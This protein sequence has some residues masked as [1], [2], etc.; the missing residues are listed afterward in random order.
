MKLTF[1]FWRRFGTGLLAFLPVLMVPGGIAAEVPALEVGL[2]V[3]DISP[4]LPI[5]LA[6]YAGRKR[7]A[8]RA[9]HPLLAQALAFKNPSGE[10]F[11]FLALDNCEVSHAF[12]QPILARLAEEFQLKP[13]EVALVCSHTHS[14]PVLADTLEGMGPR[15]PEERERINNYSRLL[16]AK[17][18]ETVGAALTNFQPAWLE[19]GTGRATFAMN[20]RVYADDKVVFGD[21]P[22]GPADWD[23]PVLRIKTTDGTLRAIVF[24]YSCHGTSVRTGDDWYV[25]SGEYMAYARQHLETLHPG[26]TAMFLTGMGADSDPAP[27]GRLLDAKRHGLELAGAVVGV[28]DHP[29][30]PVRGAFKL[31]YEEVDLP[32]ADPPTREQIEKDA[33]GKDIYVQHRAAAYLQRMKENQPLPQ[34]VKLPVAALRVGEDLTFLIVGGEVVVDYSHRLKRALS[35]DHPWTV[36][37]AYEV[38]C[39]IPSARLIKE[40]G[41]ETESSLIYY[42]LYG[43]FRGRVEDLLVNRLSAMVATLRAR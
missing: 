13:G 5:W 17:L 35:Q 9:E 19:Q 32:L 6:G 14:G 37:Y 22:D 36:G 26:A 41:Y 18:V 23:V 12:V 29:M 4:D 42:G 38:P 3:R 24:G 39:Y 30:R 33:Q 40:G 20:R 8:D 43:P 16:R 1:S 7:A 11:V 25:V 34:S 31:A 27:R 21:N 10:R 15:A 28:L 2:A